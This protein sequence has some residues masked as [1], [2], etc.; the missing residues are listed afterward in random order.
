[1]NWERYDASS[2]TDHSYYKLRGRY[3]WYEQHAAI[4][5]WNEP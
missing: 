1:L 3:L 4:G 2:Q 5:V